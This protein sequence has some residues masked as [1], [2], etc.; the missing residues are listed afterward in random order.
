MRVTATWTLITPFLLVWL[1]L[2]AAASHPAEGMPVNDISS[3]YSPNW[4]MKPEWGIDDLTFTQPKPEWNDL[5]Q[6][7]QYILAGVSRSGLPSGEPLDP[8]T[9]DIFRVVRAYYEEYGQIPQVL[10]DEII[11][12]TPGYKNIS[13]SRLAVYRNPL[14]GDW[15]L[16]NASTPSPGDV[17]IRSLTHNE[18]GHFA[19]LVPYYQ[20]LWFDG[21]SLNSEGD[22]SVSSQLAS[23]VYYIRVYGWS[24]PIVETFQ[25]VYKTDGL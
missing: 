7:E 22:Y 15:P 20:H 5:T 8:W 1:T 24:G 17:Y 19:V 16:L 25:Y 11:R 23:D 2:P 14:T 12:S 18:M 4:G 13:E 21:L 3:Q 10:N 6:M 9:T